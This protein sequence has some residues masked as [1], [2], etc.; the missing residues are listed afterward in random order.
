MRE[1]SKSIVRRQRDPNFITKYFV[2]KGLDIGGLPD[3][4]SLYSEFFP[5]CE[6][7]EIWDW[8]DGDAQYLKGLE[9][10]SQDFIVSSHCLEHLQD[11]IEGL[12]NWIRV[13]KPGG[14]LIITVPDEDLYEQGVF[15]SNKNLDHK[16]SFTILKKRSWSEASINIIQVLSIFLEE[17]DIRKIEVLDSTYR[18]DL[19][20]YDQTATPVGESAIE[21]IL[22]KRTSTEIE[23]GTNRVSSGKQPNEILRRYYNQYLMDYK[24]LKHTNNGVPPFMNENE[25]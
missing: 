15:P 12:S 5:L 3:P 14:H 16:N 8:E 2:G 21:L 19:P 6:S 23:N 18:Y 22:R 11:P 20:V 24:N 10:N 25:L 7:V 9:S 17:L 13:T 4:L 1:L